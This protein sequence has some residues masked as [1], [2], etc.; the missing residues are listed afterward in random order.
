MEEEKNFDFSEIISAIENFDP[1]NLEI[2]AENLVDAAKKFFEENNLN[3]T[4]KSIDYFMRGGENF[5]YNSAEFLR[6]LKKNKFNFLA[7]NSNYYLKISFL[8]SNEILISI[9]NSSGKNLFQ[10]KEKIN[11]KN[12]IPKNLAKNFV[13]KYLKNLKN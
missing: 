6:D 13:A 4:T 2:F 1:N 9:L 5:S 12:E 7:N 8:N 10:K 11:F 3:S